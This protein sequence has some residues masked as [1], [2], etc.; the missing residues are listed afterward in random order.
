MTTALLLPVTFAFMA[1]LFAAT[2]AVARRLDNYGIV[3]I[4]WS[5]AFGVLAI[6]YAV[7][8]DGWE[9]RRWII[10]AMAVIWSVRLGTHLAIRVARHHPEEDVRYHA[11][12]ER[13]K[14]NFGPEMFRF[15]QYQAISV[16]VLGLPFLLSAQNVQI[17]LS[18]LELAG[19]LIWVLA[20]IGESAAD[21][22]LARFKSESRNRGQVCA[23]GLWRFSRHPNY[24]FEWLIWV[25]FAVF[26]L[27]APF[28]WLGLIA[29]VAI[30]YL[31]LRKTGIPMTEEQSLQSKGDA[32]RRYQQTTSAFVPWFPRRA[33]TQIN[34]QLSTNVTR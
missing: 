20:I 26:A 5:Y 6:L 13:W 15:Y 22:Q 30:L 27:S 18:G 33:P 14:S 17:G 34:E 7:V 32:Y 11:L 8:G 16:P 9:T 25:G 29:P 24:F 21:A 19:A 1:L 28:G 2:F 10:A 12:R 4:V 31:L 23:V 3:D